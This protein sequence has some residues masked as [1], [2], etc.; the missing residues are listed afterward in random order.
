MKRAIYLDDRE[1]DLARRICDWVCLKAKDELV[2]RA[3]GHVTKP[4]LIWF[5]DEIQALRAK[6]KEPETK[7][8]PDPPRPAP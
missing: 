4:A 8:R 6:F 2:A 5:Y 1:R 3:T 7:P